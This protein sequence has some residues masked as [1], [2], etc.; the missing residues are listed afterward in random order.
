MFSVYLPVQHIIAQSAYTNA[1]SLLQLHPL[2]YL[3]Y[4]YS[5]KLLGFQFFPNTDKRKKSKKLI[6]RSSRRGLPYAKLVRLLQ[7]FVYVLERTNRAVVWGVEGGGKLPRLAFFPLLAF[8]CSPPPMLKLP[9]FLHSWE[10]IDDVE[11]FNLN[12]LS[13]I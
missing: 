10:L 1:P 13:F 11:F 8:G 6:D 4:M 12:N 9:K 7:I 5:H 3:D 2:M